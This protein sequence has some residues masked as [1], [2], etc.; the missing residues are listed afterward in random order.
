MLITRNQTMH[1]EGVAIGVLMIQFECIARSRRPNTQSSFC[2]PEQDLIVQERTQ[3][4]RHQYN[5]SFAI[6]LT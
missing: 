1:N 3:T 6:S 4:R 5:I 2:N